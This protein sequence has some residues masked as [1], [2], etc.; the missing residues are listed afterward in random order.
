MEEK[1]AEILDDK[2]VAKKTN[3]SKTVTRPL[4][5]AGTSEEYENAE[6]MEIDGEAVKIP[7][8]SHSAPALAAGAGS[9]FLT[10][11]GAGSATT[12]DSISILMASTSLRASASA[13]LKT[14]ILICFV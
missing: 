5:N 13:R 8:H 7:K 1:V 3:T 12:L 6:V 9:A 4:P 2:E 14:F 11:L 10:A